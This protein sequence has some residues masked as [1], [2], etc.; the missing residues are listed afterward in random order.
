MALA[1]ASQSM[2][3]DQSRR[4][5]APASVS[6]SSTGDDTRLSFAGFS[7]H[8]KSGYGGPGPNYWSSSSESVWVDAQGRLHLKIRKSGSTWYCAEVWRDTISR[9]G[10]QRFYVIGAIDAL[11]PNAVL[12]LFVYRDDSR[13]IDIEFSR[14]G[15]PSGANGWYVVQPGAT[16]GNAHS[17]TFALTGT[18][19]THYFDWQSSWI[20]FKSIHGHY[21]EPPSGDYLIQSWLHTGGDIPDDGDDLRVHINLWLYQGAAP[22]SGQPIEVVIADAEDTDVEAGSWGAIKALYR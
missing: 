21:E 12:G 2:A 18:H 17:F 4:S 1:A 20:S 11:D 16:P 22:I 6:R 9:C 10:K 3:V 14:W 8:V 5:E 19:T 15:N 7:W 13:E